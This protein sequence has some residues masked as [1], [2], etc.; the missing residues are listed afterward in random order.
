MA[1]VPRRVFSL[2]FS[3][4]SSRYATTRSENALAKIKENIVF[5]HNLQMQL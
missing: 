2:V 5:Y 1:S 4:L 3:S